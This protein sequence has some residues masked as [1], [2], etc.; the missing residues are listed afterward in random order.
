MTAASKA[1]KSAE[2]KPKRTSVHRVRTI[3]PPA[4]RGTVSRAVI[5]KAVREIMAEQSS[6]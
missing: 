4:K 2:A 6:L 3:K 1:N 5:R